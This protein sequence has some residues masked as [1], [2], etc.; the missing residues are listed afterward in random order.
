MGLG[1]VMATA[2]IADTIKYIADIG[3][4]PVLLVLFI[5]YFINR[6]KNDDNKVKEAYETAQANMEENNKTVRE[7]EDYLMAESA[8]REEIIRKEAEARERLIRQ[9]SEKRES[10]LMASQDRMLDTLDNIAASL[11]KME[12]S[13]NKTEG[14]LSKLEVAFSKTEKRLDTIERKVEHGCT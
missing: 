7:R 14:A 1:V 2:S 8:K 5:W 3:L 10:I 6:S 11:N 12:S 4:A 9:E 13:L